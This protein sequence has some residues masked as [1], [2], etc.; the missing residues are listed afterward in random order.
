[1]INV[2]QLA[3]AETLID[4]LERRGRLLERP[5]LLAVGGRCRSMPLA[6]RG[7][8]G[9]AAKAARQ[10]L[11]HHERLPMPLERARTQLVC[12]QLNRRQ[13]RRNDASADINAALAVFDDLGCAPWGARARAELDRMTVRR[14][15]GA[16]L[17]RSERR[18]AELVASGMTNREVGAE[19]FISPKTVEANLSRIYRKL[20]IRSRTALAGLI[21][22]LD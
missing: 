14:G 6:A 17:T 21:D 10:A 19:L 12:G 11:V 18:V 5:R 8:V 15:D 13:R 16:Q 7:E 20:G 9:A 1:M 3:E 4:R 22:P 2:D